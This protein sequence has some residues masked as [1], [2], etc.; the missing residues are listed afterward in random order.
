MDALS[1][2][3][4]GQGQL[5][6]KKIHGVK[7]PVVKIVVGKNLKA[8][9]ITHITPPATLR[10]SQSNVIVVPKRSKSKAFKGGICQRAPS[11]QT[12]QVPIPLVKPAPKVTPIK[13][14]PQNPV[15]P[16]APIITPTRN[17]I[18]GPP[19]SN[20]HEV[21]SRAAILV[22]EF[23]ASKGLNPLDYSPEI[24]PIAKKHAEQMAKGEAAFSH[25]GFMDRLKQISKTLQFK[26]GGE[27]LAKV[28]GYKDPA[29]AS[30]AGWIESEGHKENMLRDYTK[31][32]IGVAKSSDGTFFLTQIFTK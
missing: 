11:I 31:T 10:P 5:V 13:L 26:N 29:A 20:L 28:K 23:R 14:R 30:L 32:A 9:T 7:Q 2:P 12:A 24:F 8:S 22:N 6:Y 27:N 3:I 17:R 4:A 25:D 21:A 16:Q 18:E 1:S 19:A 15:T